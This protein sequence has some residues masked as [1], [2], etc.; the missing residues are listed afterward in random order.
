MRACVAGLAARE[1]N[2]RGQP[3]VVAV[4][5]VGH[6]EPVTSVG[7]DRVVETIAG[8]P[9]PVE[10]GRPG[11]GARR[12]RRGGLERRG[13]I[14]ELAGAIGPPAHFPRRALGVAAAR[15][16]AQQLAEDLVRVVV[17][18]AGDEVRGQAV[19]RF[20]SPRAARK[21]AGQLP[22]L[23]LVPAAIAQRLGG[24]ERDVAR[25]RGAGFAVEKRPKRLASLAAVAEVVVR[26]RDAQRHQLALVRVDGIERRI[27]RLGVG[28]ALGA[29]EPL[30]ARQAALERLRGILGIPQASDGHRRHRGLR[31][32][33]V[34]VVETAI[35]FERVDAVSGRLLDASAHHPHVFR[36][37]QL[38]GRQRRQRGFD[39]LRRAARQRRLGQ[40][41]RR[42]F[43]QRTFQRSR[44]Q[45][46]Q[47]GH[48]LV[49]AAEADL[50]DAAVIGGV[51]DE[52]RI[53][54]VRRRDQRKPGRVIAVGDRLG[55]LHETPGGGVE[56][57]RRRG[58]ARAARRHEPVERQIARQRRVCRRD[59]Q[60]VQA[61]PLGVACWPLSSVAPPATTASTMNARNAKPCR[62]LRRSLICTCCLDYR[63][64]QIR[65]LLFSYCVIDASGGSQQRTR[66]PGSSRLLHWEDANPG[67]WVASDRENP[68]GRIWLRR[69]FEIVGCMPSTI[70]S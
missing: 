3:S 47:R 5:I 45:Q 6:D 32:Q 65:G 49:V 52:V 55:A 2:L 61:R 34:V 29:V 35:R 18:V 30:G 41:K 4:L 48:R 8:T 12:H 22:G 53:S 31:A 10:P 51:V 44:G 11:V 26:R 14:A 57:P 38:V 17:V 58:T 9:G 25:F 66:L 23:P 64:A 19:Q 42:E 28:P 59:E 62:W 40:L 7:G 43:L 13:R 15:E 67:A 60:R 39:A 54:D 46:R 69:G 21:I 16:Q 70:N 36:V 37:R 20:L 33:R 56:R 50:R 24:E 68:G 63:S 1:Q 27:G